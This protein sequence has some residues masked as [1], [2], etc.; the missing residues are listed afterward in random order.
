MKKTARKNE[1][2]NE[3]LMGEAR[4]IIEKEGAKGWE[5]AKKILKTQ[6]TSNP[7]LQEAINYIIQG[8]P[9]FFRPAFLSFCSKAVG[10]SSDPTVP[11][12][13]SLIFFSKAIGIHDD[14]IDNLRT[15]NH[16]STFFGR[17][18]KDIALI[19]SDIL[20]FKGF[21]LLRRFDEIGVPPQSIAEILNTI[22]RI[23]FEQSEG[24]ILEISS[25]GQTDVTTEECLAKI[26][27]RA[28]EFEAIARIGGILG[29]GSKGK[30]GILGR[31]GRNL[32]IMTLL[33][34]EIIDMLELDAL[35]HRIKY[36]SLPLPI[37]Y[38]MKDNKAKPS[39]TSLISK[40]KLTRTDLLNISRIADIAGGISFTS[41]YIDQMNKE[42]Q[43]C[44]NSFGKK[45][46]LKLIS[47]SLLISP[48][49]WK[50]LLKSGLR[51]PVT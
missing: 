3:E 41:T 37:I 43:L 13:V 19:L 38:A 32:G 11:C 45:E 18:G 51:K 21:T 22:D 47:N 16:R 44:L 24:E 8:P 9:D 42:I 4:K 17:F 23:W 15:R 35:K 28:S 27:M 25:R 20:L 5:L 46:E 34:D 36:E 31:L 29:N 12:S 39:I 50:P 14:I 48:N 2:K 6:R 49:N 10:G 30:V 7:Q 26:R 33:R 40:K 1:I